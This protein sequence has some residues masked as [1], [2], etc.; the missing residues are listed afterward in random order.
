M[1]EAFSKEQFRDAFEVT[2]KVKN[3][4]APFISKL[5]EQNMYTF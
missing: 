1:Q 3:K 2:T 5:K 4:L